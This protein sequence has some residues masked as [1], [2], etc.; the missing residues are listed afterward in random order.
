M[1]DS[2]NPAVNQ[3][4]GDMN[5][6]GNMGQWS[7]NGAFARINYDYKGRY[8]VEL[9]GRYDGSSKFKKGYR[10]QFFPSVS[11]AWRA[12]E[13]KFFESMKDWCDNLSYVLR[14]DLWVIRW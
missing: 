4:T 11:V 14:T 12:S 3:A 5:I 2:N 8:L 1:I 6:D 9:N 7:V 13:E 10:Y